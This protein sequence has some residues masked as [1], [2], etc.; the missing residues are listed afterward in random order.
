[1]NHFPN[2]PRLAVNVMSEHHCRITD[3][4]RKD[5]IRLTPKVE[6]NLVRSVGASIEAFVQKHASEATYR[7]MHDALRDLWLLSIGD[8]PPVGQLRAR[9]A[10]LPRTCLEHLKLR[11]SQVSSS[12]V[13]D[14]DLLSWARNTDAEGLLEMIRVISADGAKVVSRS[15]GGGRHSK[16]RLEP[17]I[18]G[19]ARGS[20]EGIQ[21]GGRPSHSAQDELVMFLAID[22]SR[23]TDVEP[24][25]GRSDRHGF[26][27]LVHS[28]F[29]WI[30]EP[31]AHQA[32]RRYWEAVK[33]G[34]S[35]PLSKG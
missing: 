23:A 2:A 17:L 34:Q 5:G 18:F 20:N 14:E 25:P 13:D 32:L 27:D 16:G 7:E 26:G 33:G 28:V 21:K 4:L 6:K 29:Q 10:R 1:M 11:L 30:D 31:S 8:D 35:P 19:H 9:I 15:R 12:I 3:C 22:W 24:L